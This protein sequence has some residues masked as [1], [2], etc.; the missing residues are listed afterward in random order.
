MYV[1]VI[2][3]KGTIKEQFS[4]NEIKNEYQGVSYHTDYRS[5][6]DTR[7]E[8]RQK[9]RQSWQSIENI[10]DLK[11]GYLSQVVHKIA[12]MVI[13]YHAIGGP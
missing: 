13:K 1:T 7:E 2:D 11:E 10:K 6:L 12:Q 3:G 4:M 5:L 9:A 8:E